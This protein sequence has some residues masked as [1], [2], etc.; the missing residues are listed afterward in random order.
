[1]SSRPGCA[2]GANIENMMERLGIDAG[3]RVAPRFGLLFSCALRNCRSC[4]ART[5]CAEWLAQDSARFGPPQFCPNADL[6]WE[7]LHDT[8]IAR[9]WPAIQA[10]DARDA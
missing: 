6:F 2:P 1:M 5:A 10:G 8:S 3:S 7:L 9:R 4:V